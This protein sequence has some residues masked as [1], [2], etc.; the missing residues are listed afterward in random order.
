[1]PVSSA[2]VEIDVSA[3]EAVLGSLSSMSAIS[4]YGMKD[5][6]IVIVIDAESLE[7]MEENTR[8]IMSLEGVIGVF[9]VYSSVDE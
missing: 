1:M 9:P 2:I 8:K 7:I 6:K 3:G 4:V 5:N